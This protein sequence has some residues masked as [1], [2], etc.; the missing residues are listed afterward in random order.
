LA[1]QFFQK[2][3]KYYKQLAGMEIQGGENPGGSG[4]PGRTT[5]PPGGRAQKGLGHRELGSPEDIMLDIITPLF[6]CK[7]FI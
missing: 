7:L 2:E 6:Y 5:G 3:E 1:R 4:G